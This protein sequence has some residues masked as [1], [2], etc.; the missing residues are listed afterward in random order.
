MSEHGGWT[1]KDR[2]ALVLSTMSIYLTIRGREAAR[3]QSAE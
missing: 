2:S 3:R 1:E